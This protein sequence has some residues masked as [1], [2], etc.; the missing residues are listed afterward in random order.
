MSP[1]LAA[2]AVVAGVNKTTLLRAIKAGKVSGNKDDTASGTSP[3]N[4]IRRPASSRG[5]LARPVRSDPPRP[6]TAGRKR[7]PWRCVHYRS[8][9]GPPASGGIAASHDRAL[10]VM[11]L[12]PLVLAAGIALATSTACAQDVP[13]VEVCTMEK[14]M[15]RRTSCLQSNVDFLQKLISNKCV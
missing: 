14:S 9:P 2:A 11:M 8:R 10:G 13:G 7:R 12:K 5:N 6:R 4:S 15:V 3:L 1:A